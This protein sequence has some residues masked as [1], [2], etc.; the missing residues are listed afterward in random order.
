M[1]S[2]SDVKF[3]ILIP[4]YKVRFFK[5]CIE[6]CV[7]Q[8]FEDFEIIIM[9]D[10]SPEDVKG[11]VNLFVDRRI[12]YYRN[13][14]NLGKKC[15]TDV[16]NKA[17]S[18]CR[19]E[20]VICMGDDDRLLRDCLLIYN[21]YTEKYPEAEVFHIRSQIIDEEGNVRDIQEIREEMESSYCF[22]WNEIRNNRKHFIGDYLFNRS[23]LL[24]R[25]GFYR[26]PLAWG[27]DRISVLE[28]IGKGA[29]INC[30]EY[31]FQ[32][33]QN[34][35]SITDGKSSFR[36]AAGKVKARILTDGWYREYFKNNPENEEDRIYLEQAKA[37]YPAFFKEK[38]K[39]EIYAELT[40]HPLDIF[41]WIRTGKR[42]GI[43]ISI[44]NTAFVHAFYSVLK[45][46]ITGEK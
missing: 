27:S 9:D 17:L 24:S 26:L 41:K 43:S 29:L 21:R 16:W 30:S 31:G 45:K 33:R 37:Y 35:C 15:L 42:D 34:S 25:G 39:D 20:Y 19:G 5:E 40:A 44:I 23:G 28:A 32:Y 8:S 12:R 11:I 38:I 1:K 4:A 10:A 3:S 6:S 7:N 13:R 46:K 2:Y 18:V 36:S 22:V 14:K